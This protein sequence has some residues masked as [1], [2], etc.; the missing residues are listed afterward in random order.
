MGQMYYDNGDGC[1]VELQP[2]C[3]QCKANVYWTL[4]SGREGATGIATCANHES[5]TRIIVDISAMYICAWE[6]IVM[7]CKDGSVIIYD[8]SMRKVPYRVERK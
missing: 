5:A 3:P 1:T 8:K 4:V 6:G 7:R 2:V